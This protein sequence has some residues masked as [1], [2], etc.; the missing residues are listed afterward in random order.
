MDTVR[1]WA[2]GVCAAAL[3]CTVLRYTAPKGGVGKVFRLLLS[4]FFLCCCFL[5]LQN[6]VVPTLPQLEWQGELSVSDQ[7]QQ[8]VLQQLKQQVEQRTREV[9]DTALRANHITATEISVQ[10][11]TEADGRIYIKHV[12][13]YLDEK[14]KNK[15]VTARQI[16][17]QL[18]ET[19]VT[20]YSGKEE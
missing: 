15:A 9:A 12:G 20:V 8:Q 14:Q 6:A 5:P 7:L 10:A 1:A 2:S 18:L 3:L 13:V 16:L 19:E 17:I 11:D 4:A